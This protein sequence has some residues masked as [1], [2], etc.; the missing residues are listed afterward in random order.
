[1]WDRHSKGKSTAAFLKTL[2]SL[3]MHP[4]AAV[5][6]ALELH[7]A[8]VVLS[9]P[10]RVLS[11]SKDED[12]NASVNDTDAGAHA[13]QLEASMPAKPTRIE[14][15]RAASTTSLGYGHGSFEKVRSKTH[16]AKGRGINRAATTGPGQAWTSTQTSQTLRQTLFPGPSDRPNLPEPEISEIRGTAL[17]KQNALLP[18]PRPGTGNM[19]SRPL[20]TSERPASGR[21]KTS[22]M[23]TVSRLSGH[24]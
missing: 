8:A 6:A 11:Y 7:G 1:M 14:R 12:A 18:K 17:V 19:R 3:A 10:M 16:I 4:M 2:Q 13:P 15:I 23:L 24:F 5:H 22:P 21:A 9:S 20:V